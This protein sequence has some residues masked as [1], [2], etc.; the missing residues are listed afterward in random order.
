MVVSAACMNA[1]LGDAVSTV[2][3]DANCCFTQCCCYYCLFRGM[4][5][6]SEA[7]CAHRVGPGWRPT[8]ASG[9]VCEVPLPA[10]QA[11]ATTVVECRVALPAVA[12]G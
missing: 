10:G 12:F 3:C 7:D 6:A 8:S 5:A 9:A 4:G 1:A 2:T 11:R